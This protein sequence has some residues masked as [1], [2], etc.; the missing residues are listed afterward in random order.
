MVWVPAKSP[1][2]GPK[3]LKGAKIGII[4]FGSLGEAYTRTVLTSLGLQKE[5]RV[6]AAGGAPQLM[7]ALKAGVVD[8]AVS[9]LLSMAPLK[10]KGELRE[11]VS[12]RDFL[13]KEWSELALIAH[14]SFLATNPEVVRRVVKAVLEAT[15][16]VSKN[17]TW[18][19]EKMVSF[20]GFSPEA[21]QELYDS[22][23]LYSKDGKIERKSLETIRKFLLEHKL[24]TEEKAAPLDQL[25]TKE[26]TG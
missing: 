14:K 23:L 9:S 12:V 19:L 5:V 11:I 21:S 2:K 7:A 3:D 1:F 26:F 20:S 13:P 10:Y 8:G 15:D 18:A 17:R 24:I 25:Y 4:R 6:V 16:F 22:Q